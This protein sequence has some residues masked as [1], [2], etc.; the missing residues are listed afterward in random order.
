MANWLLE[1]SVVGKVRLRSDGEPAVSAVPKALA[2]LRGND[3]NND[4]LTIIE[5]SPNKS[6]ASLGSAE[7]WAETLGGLV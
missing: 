7:R 2:I 1:T 4:P 6:S 3:V 5:E